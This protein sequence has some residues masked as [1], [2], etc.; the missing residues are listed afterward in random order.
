MIYLDYAATS[1][2]KPKT[3]YKAVSD[4]MMYYSANPGRGGH[5][6]SAKAGEIVYE[7]REK[8]SNFFHVNAPEQ[9]SFFP[10]ATAAL[11]TGIKGVLHPGDHVVVSSMEHNSVA[12]PLESLRKQGIITYSVVQGDTNGSLMPADFLIAMKSNTRLVICTQASNVCG[13]VYDVQKISHLV[14]KQGALF[15]VD[16]AQSAGVLDINAQE[17]DLLAFPGHKGLYGPQ[18]SGCLYVREGLNLSTIMEGGTGSQSEQL[19]QPDEFP[20]RLESGTLNVPAIAGLGAA[21]D[22]ISQAGIQTIYNHE[23]ELTEYFSEEMKNM[24]KIALY[25]NQNKVG[26]VALNIHGQDCVDVAA[27]LN[28]QF[29]IAVRSGLH[30]APWAHKTIGTLET[31]CI[32]FSFGYFTTKKEVKKAIDAIFYIVKNSV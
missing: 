12:R 16:A 2:V 11:N 15:M 4:A 24:K 17:F 25:G 9:F 28:D 27:E 8:L 14:R 7:T 22:F 32:R 1:F 10:N 23:R 29:S 13:N 6:P 26:V 5:T 30:C 20:D 3:V 19:M 18:G 21:V 31:G